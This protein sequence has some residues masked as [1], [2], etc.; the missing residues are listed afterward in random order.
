MGSR[1]PTYLISEIIG[2]FF[3]IF[4]DIVKLFVYFVGAQM[5][6]VILVSFSNNLMIV[7]GLIFIE[8]GT[9]HSK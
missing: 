2:K 5:K 6:I 9:D 7:T 8:L 1:T 4:M 3:F